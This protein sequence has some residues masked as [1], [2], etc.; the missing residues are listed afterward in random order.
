MKQTAIVSDPEDEAL[1]EQL[2]RDVDLIMGDYF[3]RNSDTQDMAFT[4]MLKQVSEQTLREN[5]K[6]K[7]L[8]N[9]LERTHANATN[10]T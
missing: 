9:Y 10:T 5:K 4:D 1:M 2:K 3:L 6:L 8:I 7:Q